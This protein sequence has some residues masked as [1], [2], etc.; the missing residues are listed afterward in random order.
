MVE[1]GSLMTTLQ[2][3]TNVR[4]WMSTQQP[5][6][7]QILPCFRMKTIYEAHH[8]IDYIFKLSMSKP[9]LSGF[10]FLGEPPALASTFYN[11]K[12]PLV[13]VHKF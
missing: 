5:F 10:Y 8:P 7:N 9:V 2:E 3:L 4:N 6:L 12:E 11:L 13:I 1:K